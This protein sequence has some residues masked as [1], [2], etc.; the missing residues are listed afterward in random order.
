MS[1]WWIGLLVGCCGVGLAFAHDEH[2]HTEAHVHGKAN[3]DLVMQGQ[4]LELSLSTPLDNVVGFEYK[5]KTEADKAKLNKAKAVLRSADWVKLSPAAQ[6]KLKKVDV[7]DDF[8]DAHADMEV[9]VTF[10]CQKPELLQELELGLFK[11]FPNLHNLDVQVALP[12]KQFG[13]KLTAKQ[14]KLVLQ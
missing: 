10:Q 7:E 12:N 14:T 2:A 3:L 1:K 9:E 6:C 11:S 5:P 8:H 13:A 4:D